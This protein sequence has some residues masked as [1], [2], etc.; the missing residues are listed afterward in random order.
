MDELQPESAQG[1][2]VATHTVTPEE[3]RQFAEI[4]GLR[5]PL[6]GRCSMFFLFQLYCAARV[7]VLPFGDPVKIAAEARA[8]EGFGHPA[9]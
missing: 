3:V 9:S 5:S 1:G 2:A 7:S 8:L 6:I 4:I